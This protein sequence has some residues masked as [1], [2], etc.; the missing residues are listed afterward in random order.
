V[1][2]KE[3]FF[4]WTLAKLHQAIATISTDLATPAVRGARRHNIFDS[5]VKVE[6]TC[7][8]L[9]IVLGFSIAFFTQ[10]HP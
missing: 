3:P 5:L 2:V 9:L 4:A 8:V 1:L 7:W 10:C 6:P